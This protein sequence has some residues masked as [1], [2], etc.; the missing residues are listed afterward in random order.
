MAR[1]THFLTLVAVTKED[2]IYFFFFP[3]LSSSSSPSLALQP[4]KFSLGFPDINAHSIPPTAHTSC[5]THIP[6]I[7]F[8]PPILN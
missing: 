4:F 8:E 5:Y 3:F 1:I 7:Q 2:H 6:Q